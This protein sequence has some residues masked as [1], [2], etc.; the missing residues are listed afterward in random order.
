[1]NH[2]P[3]LPD[4]RF[5]HQ[6]RSSA[7]STPQ[8]RRLDPRLPTRQ[9]DAIEIRARSSQRLIGLPNRKPRSPQPPKRNPPQ[10]PTRPNPAPKSASWSAS[11]F[12]TTKSSHTS[13]GS[14]A[15]PRKSRSNPRKPKSSAKASRDS[16]KPRNSLTPC[17]NGHLMPVY[18]SSNARAIVARVFSLRAPGLAIMACT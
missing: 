1:M 13:A 2:G 16:P 6:R 9:E 10:N 11:I 4:F 15:S 8:S 18:F 5:R 12:P 7:A 14:I 3:R 17:P